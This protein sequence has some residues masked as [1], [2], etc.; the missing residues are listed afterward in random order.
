MNKNFMFIVI[1]LLFF[2]I[3]ISSTDKSDCQKKTVYSDTT[4]RRLGT[5]LED[6][7]CNIQRTTDS[8]RY[9]CVVSLDG[10]RCIE[11][12]KSDCNSF[13]TSSRLRSLSSQLNTEDCQNLRTS[14]NERYNCVPNSMKERCTEQAKS[15]C[16]AETV[17]DY[18]RRLSSELSEDICNELETTS[19]K[20]KCVLSD[21]R[22]SCTE[23]DFSYRLNINKLSLFAFCLLFFL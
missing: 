21:D 17:S 8:E 7:D 22:K 1:F 6:S 14:D 15:E 10:E 23:K 9:I 19:E 13:S 18:D 20:K 5:V 2:N 12:V 3:V 11:V 4:G 16:Y